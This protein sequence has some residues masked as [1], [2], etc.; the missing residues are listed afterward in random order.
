[1]VQRISRPKPSLQY[2]Q[3]GA[4][5]AKSA[6][7]AAALQKFASKGGGAF[8]TWWLQSPSTLHQTLKRKLRGWQQTEQDISL[9]GPSCREVPGVLTILR[10]VEPRDWCARDV[11]YHPVLSISWLL[12]LLPIKK[13]AGGAL[14]SSTRLWRT[15][16]F[17]PKHLTFV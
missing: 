8:T 1:M 15:L 11:L 12:G 3:C 13:V 17:L 7:L 9:G 16:K 10:Q 5:A 6:G 14:T 2:Y 4:H